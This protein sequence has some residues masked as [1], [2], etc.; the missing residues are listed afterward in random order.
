MC[1]IFMFLDNILHANTISHL[2]VLR[3][4]NTNFHKDNKTS[5]IEIPFF[6]KVSRIE[7]QYANQAIA[8]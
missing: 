1:Q 8:K 6:V 7:I 5:F 2:V 3:P 4:E